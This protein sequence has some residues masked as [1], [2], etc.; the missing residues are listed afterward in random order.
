MAVLV[1]T[2][3]YCNCFEVKVANGAVLRTKGACHVVSLKI[4]G[5]N[6]LLDLNVLALGGCDVVLGTQWLYIEVAKSDMIRESNMTN[7][8]INR[9]WVEVKWVQ[10]IFGLT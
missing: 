8:F 1:N 9:S 5:A 10:V 2:L 4:Q 6:F 7:L 3:I